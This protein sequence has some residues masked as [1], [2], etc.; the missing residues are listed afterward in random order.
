MEER[1][2]STI[3]NA[4]I[5]SDIIQTRSET[6]DVSLFGFQ[7]SSI[8][9]VVLTGNVNKY[10]IQSAITTH[11]VII[12][13]ALYNTQKGMVVSRMNMTLSKIESAQ[14]TPQTP[15]DP[16]THQSLVYK[17]ETEAM[18]KLS[19]EARDAH[20]SDEESSTEVA[21]DF[22]KNLKRPSDNDQNE[23]ASFEQAARLPEDLDQSIDMLLHPN[24]AF[25]E[26]MDKQRVYTNIVELSKKIGQELQSAEAIQSEATLA[27]FNVLAALV[28]SARTSEL[29]RVT[30]DLRSQDAEEK[31]PAQIAAW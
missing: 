10:T 14:G 12:S 6:N 27:K 31:T 5:L 29:K 19:R 13:P 8:S 25:P 9:R 21:K 4:L 24:Y 17:Y 16:I 23:D 22:R 2:R 11:K 7:R 18:K 26:A 1:L 3:E 30:K 20:E 15:T 28:R